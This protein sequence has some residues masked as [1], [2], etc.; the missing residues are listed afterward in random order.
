LR[1]R[2][3]RRTDACHS[4]TSGERNQQR[5]GPAFAFLLVLSVVARR[6]TR[7]VGALMRTR[8]EEIVVV[9][10]LGPAISTAGAAEHLGALLA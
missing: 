10:A 5:T 3:A 2:D 9:L 4:A 7:W 1:D 8:D 6:G